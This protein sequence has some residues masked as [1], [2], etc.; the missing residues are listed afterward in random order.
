MGVSSVPVN[1][2][3]HSGKTQIARYDP[4]LKKMYRRKPKQGVKS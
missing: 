3:A 4:L 1:N 2:I